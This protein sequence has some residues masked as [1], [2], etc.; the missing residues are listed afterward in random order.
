MR[1]ERQLGFLWGAVALSL[2]VLAPFSKHLVGGLPN[3][4]V[5]Q[6]SGLP[7]PGCGTTRAAMELAGFDVVGALAIN[8]LATLAWGALVAGGL[9]AGLLAVL[10]RSP[11]EP[12]WRL[13]P[14]A[15]WLL[16]LVLIANWLFLVGTGA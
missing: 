1:S 6:F 3:C 13:A 15:R 14:T 11:A 2:L 9:V 7:C 12:D 16:A 5:K 10:D 4:P 8:P